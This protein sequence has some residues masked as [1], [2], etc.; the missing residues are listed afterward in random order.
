MTT[1]LISTATEPVSVAEAK[2]RLRLDDFISDGVLAGM[3]TGARELCEQQVCRAIALSTYELRIDAFPRGEIRLTWPPVASVESI[4]YLDAD[5]SEQTLSPTLY[6]LDAHS[7]PGWILPAHG[8]D[9]PTTIAAAN[10][11]T[12]RYVAG[13]GASCPES[14]KTWIY[15]HVAA[16]VRNLEIASD[17]PMT[18]LPYAD[19]YLDRWRVY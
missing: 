4:T 6:A 17:R 19:S 16:A 11:V 12:V 3:I 15:L 9:W 2:L 10:A 1:R 8:A 14:L 18:I 13:Y 5:G 7:E